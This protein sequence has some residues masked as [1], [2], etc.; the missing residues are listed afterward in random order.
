MVKR[1]PGLQLD[2]KTMVTVIQIG[3]ISLHRVQRSVQLMGG[4]NFMYCV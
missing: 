3:G 1:D 2:R 4:I